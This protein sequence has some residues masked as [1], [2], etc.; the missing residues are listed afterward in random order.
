MK[1]TRIQQENELRIV[2]SALKLFSTQGYRGTTVDEIARHSGMSKTNVL[3]YF[4]HKTDVYEAVLERTLSVWVKPLETLNADGDPRTEL[5]QYV[6]AKLAMSRAEPEASRLFAGEILSGAKT[7]GP[8]FDTFLKSW[9]KDTCSALQQWMDQ[10][11]LVS[12]D[13]LHVLFLLWA[14]TQHYA[15]FAPQINALHDGTEDEL[16]DQA[17]HMLIKVVVDGLVRTPEPL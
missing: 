13:P 1:K 9:V 14:T 4:K 8:K 15:D 10:G 7:I 12:V 2:K 5:I 17:E 16:F 3:Y 6:K 11:K